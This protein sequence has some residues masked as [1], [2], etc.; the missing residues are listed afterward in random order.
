MSPLMRRMGMSRMLRTNTRI[1]ARRVALATFALACLTAGSAQ[2]SDAGRAE[3]LYTRGLAELHAGHTDAALALFQ[4]SVEADPKD[5]HGLYYRGV[6]FGRAGRYEEAVA[7]LKQVVAASDLSLERDRLELGYALYRLERYEEAAAELEI[8]SNKGTSSSSEAMLLLGIVEIRRGHYEAA[9]TALKKAENEDP[10]KAVPARYYQGLAAYRQGH[11]EE[12]SEQFSWVNQQGGNSPY[13]R[14][15][16]AFLASL[17]SG[18]GRDYFL[19]GGLAFEYDSNVALAPDNGNVASNL[20]GISGEDDGRAVMTAGGKYA[21]V[22]TPTLRMAVG[23]DFLASLH[24]DL[25]RFDVQTHRIGTDTQY[26]YG[27]LTFGLATAY[28]FAM[29]DEESL[30][31]G[32]AV[33]PWLRIDEGTF[34]RTEIYYRMRA[35]DYVLAPYSAQRDSINNAVGG[36]QFFSLG[37]YDRNV[38]LGYRFDNDSAERIAGEDYD[39]NGDQFEAGIEWAFCP[40]LRA[41]L[42]FAYK[43]ENYSEASSNRDDDEYL[44]IARVEKKILPYT[45]LMASYIFDRNV[46]DQVVFDYTRHITSLGVEVRY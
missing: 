21:I 41:D 34:G 11:N 43:L 24:F 44:V 33:L 10:T 23:Y 45:W 2:A 35:R 13:V 12:A 14:E 26:V 27:P 17:R 18:G 37:A 32:G 22:N 25:E 8:A 15:S 16:S 6:G 39:Y 3:R 38:I 1:A 30:S 19:H 29:L 5:V 4:Q 46:S 36:R 7:D 28:E 20:L 9:T 40:E 31:H 42:T